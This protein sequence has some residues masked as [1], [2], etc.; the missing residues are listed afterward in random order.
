M[1]KSKTAPK[2]LHSKLSRKITNRK[3]IKKMPSNTQLKLTFS[4]I[5]NT[6]LKVLTSKIE[7][8]SIIPCNNTNYPR[9][10]SINILS[11]RQ[12]AL[13]ITPDDDTLVSMIQ[14]ELNQDII[15]KEDNTLIS[16]LNIMI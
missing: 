9:K 16:L 1:I 3:K 7:K 6:R 15:E 8:N 2:G 14:K 10:E 4:L 5:P 13:L 12:S 11:R